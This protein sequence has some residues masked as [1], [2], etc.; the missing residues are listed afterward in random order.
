MTKRIITLVGYDAL[1]E[2]YQSI[3]GDNP[4]TIKALNWLAT[5]LKKWPHSTILDVGSGTGI[6]TARFL[7]DKEFKVIGLDNSMKMITISRQNVPEATF[8]EINIKRNLLEIFDNDT[9]INFQAITAFFTLLHIEKSIFKRVL[10]NI[11]DL[12]QP[13]G[14]FILSMINGNIDEEGLF[15]NQKAHFTAYN[16]DDL[17]EIL[18]ELGL[19]IL[20]IDYNEFKPNIEF[21]EVEDQIYFYCKKI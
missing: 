19:N 9:K 10:R 11:I 2:E 18:Q 13:G 14:F 15:L 20:E 12:L 4:G 8:K 5:N 1:A 3:Y 21:S 6:P 17:V 16:E 7:V